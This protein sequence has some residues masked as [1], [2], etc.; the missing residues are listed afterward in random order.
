MEVQSTSSSLYQNVLA[1]LT[2]QDTTNSLNQ[3][4][5]TTSQGVN[6]T[7][8]VESASAAASSSVG[9]QGFSAALLEQAYRA[10]LTVAPVSAP[11]PL[12]PKAPTPQVDATTAISPVG[13]FAGSSTSGREIFQQLASMGQSASTSQ[14]AANG[15]YTMMQQLLSSEPSG[16]SSLDVTA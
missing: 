7:S 5:A 16:S 2:G 3:T 11:A 10:P 4:S 14:A 12:E 1:S 15:S 8:Q 6:A 9:T 13:A